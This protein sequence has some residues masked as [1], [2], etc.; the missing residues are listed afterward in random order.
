MKATITVRHERQSQLTSN[1]CWESASLTV[2]RFPDAM[3]RGAAAAGD[4]V[5]GRPGGDAGLIEVF[6]EHLDRHPF[7]TVVRIQD[8]YTALVHAVDQPRVAQQIGDDGLALQ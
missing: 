4:V 3:Q 2:E 6:L 5:A 1:S 7:H 8:I